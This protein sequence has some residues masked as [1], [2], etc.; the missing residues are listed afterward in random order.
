MPP[1][2]MDVCSQFVTASNNTFSL[3][4]LNRL[5]GADSVWKDIFLAVHCLFCK[6]N[7]HPQM[8]GWFSLKQG[9]IWMDSGAVIFMPVL[10]ESCLFHFLPAALQRLPSS[11]H[12]PDSGGWGARDD[13]IRLDTGLGVGEVGIRSHH[14]LSDHRADG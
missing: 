4:L 1:E 2:L 3:F 12:L 6:G 14:P 10:P 9:L 11:S 7:A 13:V 8:A 5:P